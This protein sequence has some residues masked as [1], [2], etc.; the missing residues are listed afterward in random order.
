MAPPAAR[1]QGQ[2]L[3]TAAAGAAI[4]AAGPPKRTTGRRVRLHVREG[5]A[6]ACGAAAAAA[7]RRRAEER[8]EGAKESGRARA[9]SVDGERERERD[10]G[11]PRQCGCTWKESKVGMQRRSVAHS[12]ERSTES[13]S[14]KER[15][16]QRDKRLNE[17]QCADSGAVRSPVV[18]PLPTERCSSKKRAAPRQ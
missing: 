1:P 5:G 9:Y 4:S 11:R 8:G 2:S 14:R 7:L 12:G 13:Q 6:S 16:R 15:E 10:E 17:F 3:G 18:S